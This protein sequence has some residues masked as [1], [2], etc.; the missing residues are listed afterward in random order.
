M[1]GRTGASAG[2]AARTSVAGADKSPRRL[3]VAPAAVLTHSTHPGGVG[4]PPGDTTIPCQEL[5]DVDV[6]S[7][8]AADAR[9]WN[10]AD[11]GARSPRR[12]KARN[13]RTSAK[14][15]ARRRRCSSQLPTGFGSGQSLRKTPRWSAER[16][17]VP[18]G[19]STH[20]WMRRSALHPPHF[21]EGPRT[22]SPG[23]RGQKPGGAALAKAGSTGVSCADG[24]RAQGE[25]RD[26]LSTELSPAALGT[27]PLG[28]IAPGGEA[29]EAARA[30][31]ETQSR[32]RSRRASG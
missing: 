30:L 20:D 14:C 18:K 11:T 10:G 26:G 25:Q 12:L 5:A 24:R 21:F 17:G 29:R 9:L 22:A 28:E 31:R 1:A 19:R 4:A 2:D 23:A 32:A 3:G 16:R 7:F 15:A 8:A 13:N 27:R 6:W